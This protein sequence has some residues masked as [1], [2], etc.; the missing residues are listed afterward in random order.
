[1]SDDV[2]LQLRFGVFFAKLSRASNCGN[3]EAS[4]LPTLIAAAVSRADPGGP[5]PFIAASWS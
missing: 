2:A 5:E 1:M 3:P 4:P